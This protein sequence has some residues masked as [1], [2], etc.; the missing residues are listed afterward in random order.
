MGSNCQS[1]A[2]MENKI[3]LHVK[4]ES[5]QTTLLSNWME[6]IDITLLN[7]GLVIKIVPGTCSRKAMGVNV[8]WYFGFTQERFFFK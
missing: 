5:D 1:V 4:L 8:I 6:K 7:G 3:R 2:L